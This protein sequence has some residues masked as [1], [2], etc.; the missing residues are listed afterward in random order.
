MVAC[1]LGWYAP[2]LDI[3]WTPDST[4]RGPLPEAQNPSPLRGRTQGT[5]L[6]YSFVDAL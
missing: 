4:L 6:R 5:S 1:V 2:A 3:I